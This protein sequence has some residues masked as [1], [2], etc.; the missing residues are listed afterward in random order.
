MK[1]TTQLEHT[2]ILLGIW[3][4]AAAPNSD[5]CTAPSSK[6]RWPPKMP[7]RRPKSSPT[8]SRCWTP[9][10]CSALHG[11]AYHLRKPGY[12]MKRFASNQPMPFLQAYV[13]NHLSPAIDID[14]SSLREAEVCV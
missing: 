3:T 14:I 1:T 11:G 4:T 6:S 10:T 8:K 7:V 12:A 2:R 5:S 13:I 9:A